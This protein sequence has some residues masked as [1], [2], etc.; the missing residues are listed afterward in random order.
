MIRSQVLLK[1]NLDPVFKTFKASGKWNL[2]KQQR[3]LDLAQ[4]QTTLIELL[5]DRAK[6]IFLEINVIYSIFFFMPFCDM[7]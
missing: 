2:V 6:T 1:K 4:L 7:Q 3:S 5:A